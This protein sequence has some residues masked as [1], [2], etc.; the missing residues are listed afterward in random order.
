[1]NK[2]LESAKLS[3]FPYISSKEVSKRFEKNRKELEKNL[4]VSNYSRLEE[5]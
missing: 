3:Q 4:S 5:V 2:V 1:M